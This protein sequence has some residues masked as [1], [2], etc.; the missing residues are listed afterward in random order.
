[1]RK[2]ALIA[3]RSFGFGY[4]LGGVAQVRKVQHAQRRWFF[5]LWQ[6]YFFA[7][8]TLLLNSCGFFPEKNQMDEIGE[9]CRARKEIWG[10]SSRA[11][12]AIHCQTSRLQSMPVEHPCCTLSGCVAVCKRAFGHS[13]RLDRLYPSA[14][15]PAAAGQWLW[16]PW[17]D[18][19][20]DN[21]PFRGVG[22]L[23]RAAL[24][25]FAFAWQPFGFPTCL[26]TNARVI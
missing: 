12:S 22:P 13:Q 7:F 6:I 11:L 14:A 5:R 2:G 3:I 26:I 18:P 15:L 20:G 8:M 19:F 16:V 17:A 1:M 10:S 21:I 9:T 23:W 4:R 24:S 25:P